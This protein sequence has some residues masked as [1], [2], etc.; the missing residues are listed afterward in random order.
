MKSLVNFNILTGAVNEYCPYDE[1]NP[2]DYKYVQDLMVER[3]KARGEM[4]EVTVII[5][6]LISG[7]GELTIRQKCKQEIINWLKTKI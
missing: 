4:G 7:L 1:L 3:L 6:G 5:P 2:E